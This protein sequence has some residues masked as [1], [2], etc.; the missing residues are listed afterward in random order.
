MDASRAATAG[1]RHSLGLLDECERRRGDAAQRDKGQQVHRE[2]DDRR[3]GHRQ[4]RRR[5]P[6]EL[7]EEAERQ[8]AQRLVLGGREATVPATRD[9]SKD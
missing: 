8:L 6:R 7:I 5:E 2:E 4:R 3:N 1:A 9:R